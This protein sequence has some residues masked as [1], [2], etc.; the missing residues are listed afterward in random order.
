VQAGVEH[1]R[2]QHER[3]QEFEDA[4]REVAVERSQLEQRMAQNHREQAE[5]I[6]RAVILFAD[7]S[8]RLYREPGRLNI[9]DTLTGPPVTIEIPRKASEG[10]SSM[11]IFC[12]DL[13][14]LQ[15]CR[16]RGRGPEFMVHDSHLFDG[17]DDRQV[18]HALEVAND[19]ADG[20]SFQYIT[21]MNSDIAG[22]VNAQGFNLAPH[23]IEPR[24]SDL[25]GEGLFGRQFGE[26][27]R[28]TAG[29]R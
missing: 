28:A 19:V 27:A 4:G 1:L 20:H 15:L 8:R 9:S 18:R 16:E 3:A 24:L 7:I 17:V 29:R 21:T 13:T 23:I 2:L 22:L 25:A 5:Q 6:E 10:V 11:Q 12:F 14:M 26:F